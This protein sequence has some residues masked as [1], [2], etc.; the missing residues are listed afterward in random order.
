MKISRIRRRIPPGTAPGTLTADPQGLQP[1]VYVAAYGPDYLYE[2]QIEQLEEL[3]TFIGH[4]HVTWVNVVGLGDINLIR[5]LG[6]MFSLHDLALE[7]VIHVHQRPKVE[8]YDDHVFIVTRTPLN[9]HDNFETGQI[10]IFMG[11]NYVLS[12]QENANNCFNPVRN[13]MRRQ[14]GRL[15]DSKADYL[16]YALLDAVLDGYFPMLDGYGETIEELETR[17]LERFEN[18]LVTQIHQ[19]RRDLLTMRRAIWPQR[20]MLN[21]LIREDSPLVREQTRIYLR[22]CYDHAIQL[23]DLVETYREIAS[24]LV[25]LYLSSLSTRM[26]EV[27]K[28]LTIIATIFIPLGFIAGVYGMNFDPIKSPWNMPELSWY[29]GYPLALA[30]MGTVALGLM[31]YFRHKGWVGKARL[32]SQDKK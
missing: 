18:S 13:R 24:G 26:N 23:I 15:R 29:F 4:Y 6:E 8:E 16:T 21:V 28:V 17:L 30:L 32:S 11:E 7:D 19:I 14:R 2:Q 9:S 27:M 1:T 22:D 3:Q 20:D 10:A 31:F 5:Q 12:F 25:D